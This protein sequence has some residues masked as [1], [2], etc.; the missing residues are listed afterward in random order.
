M[1]EMTERL[2][3]RPRSARRAM[4]RGARRLPRAPRRARVTCPRSPASRPA[5]CPTGSSACTC[6]SPTRWRAGPGVNPLGD[7]A[8][9]LLDRWWRAGPCV[10]VGGGP[11]WH[12]RCGGAGFDAGTGA[13]PVTARGG[14]RLRH[15]LD[16]P[17]RRRRRRRRPA[18]RRRAPDGDRAARPGRRPHRR[19]RRRRRWR[20]PSPCA[21]VRRVSAAR[22]APSGCASS[23]PRPPATRAT[24]GVRRRGARAFGDRRRRGAVTGTRRP[25]CRSAAPPALAADA[26]GCAAPT[27]SSTS[28]AARPS[29]C[30]APTTCEAA[31][32]VDVGCVRMTERHLRDD[33]PTAGPDR[34]RPRRD[35]DAAVDL[36]AE[37]VDL[38]GRRRSS[39]W[40]AR[41]PR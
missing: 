6:S 13:R 23:R 14:H 31:R 12:R 18:D 40:P 27:S 33:P 38:T 32:S 11:R 29:S 25:R 34:R 41:S 17:A 15:Q 10:P 26:A 16:P 1:R 8:L 30:A 7:E 5:A 2:R 39:D 37:T 22:S 19:H 20:A 28:A 35:I 9:A 24:R 4:P 21:R 3:D 36:A